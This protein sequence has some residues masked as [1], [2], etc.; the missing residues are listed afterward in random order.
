ME[1]L[2]SYVTQIEARKL[3][4]ILRRRHLYHFTKLIWIQIKNK[5]LPT[6]LL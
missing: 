6:N 4:A 2:K 5:A 3:P 1:P